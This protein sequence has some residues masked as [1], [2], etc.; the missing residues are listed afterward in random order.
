MLHGKHAMDRKR[1]GNWADFQADTQV[2]LGM[3]GK[4]ICF[5]LTTIYI[6]PRQIHTAPILTWRVIP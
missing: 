1:W 6:D 4:W 3:P 2:S 5:V